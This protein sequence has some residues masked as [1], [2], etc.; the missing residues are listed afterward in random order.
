MEIWKTRLCMALAALALTITLP[1]SIF[2][3][4][5]FFCDPC[6]YQPCSLQGLKIGGEAVWCK[7]CV[8]DL[9][10]GFLVK[11]SG[12]RTRVEYKEVCPEWDLGFKVFASYQNFRCPEWTIKSSWTHIRPE[13]SHKIAAGANENASSPLL[14]LSLA[15]EFKANS[16]GLFKHVKGKY[17]LLY[18]DWDLLLSYN[19][20]NTSWMQVTPSFGLAGMVL[21]QRQKVTLKNPAGINNE[22]KALIKWKSGYNALGLRAGTNVRFFVRKCLSF[23]A[24]G[25]GS[26]LAGEV[27]SRNKQKIEWKTQGAEPVTVTSRMELKDDENCHVVTGYRAALGFLYDFGLNQNFYTF[28]LGYEFADW[29]HIPNPRVYFGAD[30]GIDASHATST[31][32]RTLGFH[33]LVG[34]LSLSF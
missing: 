14:H 28:R 20:C 25:E 9:D 16:T 17:D 13:D 31:T 11:A 32:T 4:S 7:P 29:F 10:F 3:Q 5:P 22:D 33:G 23:Y 34:G 30:K 15:E 26:L 6:D 19:L 8:D 27:N 24:S 21:D 2:A 18:N 1:Q 12:N